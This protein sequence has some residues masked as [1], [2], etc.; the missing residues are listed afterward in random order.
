MPIWRPSTSHHDK[1]PLPI[2][3]TRAQG[4]YLYTADGR[5]I[6]DGTCAWWVTVHGHCH[7]HIAAAIAHQ[8]HTLDQVL[9]ADFT[10]PLAEHLI[11]RLSTLTGLPWGFFSDD[12]STAVEVALKIAIQYFR[13]RGERRTR[14]LALEGAYHGDTFGAM[15]VSARGLFTLPFEDWLFEV[16]W[17]PFPS[18]E[19]E[20]ALRQ[21][22]EKLQERRDIIAFI[23]E[24]LLQ[25]TAGMRTYAPSYWDLIATTVR[26]TGGLVIADEVFTGFG[27]TGTLFATQQC[28]QKPDILCLSKGITGGF[29]PLGVT[30]VSEQVF[31][32]FYTSDPLKA[33]YHGHSYTGNPLA[34]AAAIANLELWE[35]SHTWTQLQTLCDTQKQLAEKWRE[36]FPDL[37][38]RTLGL[39]L[40]VELPGAE[41]GYLAPHRHTFKA[42]A[43]ER[44][45]FLRPLGAV[46]YILPALSSQ[47]H[48]L[49]RAFYLIQDYL[50]TVG[51]SSA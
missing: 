7:P 27:R 10:H 32:G 28:Q 2:R 39:V 19:N 5:A 31:H 12:G 20:A 13:N 49:E 17:L 37:P 33:F 3:V 9:F 44:N 42:Y 15:S 14:L 18:P 35:E 34:C 48:E 8:A 30:L 50:E 6:W 46:V 25:G 38:V 24:P 26:Q 43:L 47:P 22:L 41:R 51:V 45:I 29:M 4:S 21:S 36:M 23:G 16:E 40:A 11:Q 1:T